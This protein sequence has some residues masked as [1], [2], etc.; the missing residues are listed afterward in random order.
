[1]LTDLIAQVRDGLTKSELEALYDA[2]LKLFAATELRISDLEKLEAL[3]MERAKEDTVASGKRSWS[4]TSE[5]QELITLKRQSK[6]TEKYLSSVK[7]K[8]FNLF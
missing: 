7:H 8:L 4:A 3:Y 5:G 1:M 2:F 6:V